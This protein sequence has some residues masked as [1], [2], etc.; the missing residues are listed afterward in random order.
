MN[1]GRIRIGVREVVVSAD[2]L[3]L[4]GTLA[5]PEGAVGVVVFAHGS[6]SSRF[7][8]RNRY[9]AEVLNDAALATLLFDLLTTDEE[10]D[11][12]N[13][14]DVSLL[15]GRLAAATNRLEVEPALCHLPIGY[16]GASTGAG[17]A[18]WAAA[19]NADAAAVVSRGGRPDLAGPRLAEVQA[20]TLLIV[21]GR[22]QVVLDLNRQALE[23]LTCEAELR[24]VQ[25]A[26]HLFEEPGAL[27]EVA[28]LARDWFVG[29][30]TVSPGR[31]VSRQ[32]GRITADRS[33]SRSPSSLTGPNAVHVTIDDPKALS[34][35]PASEARTVSGM[36]R[37]SRGRAAA[38]LGRV[39][40]SATR[41]SSRRW[42]ASFRASLQPPATNP[43]RE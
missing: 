31:Q 34:S 23:L 4:P 21:G 30:L 11:R 20:P 42:R 3:S 18:L 9:V 5:V 7:S 39:R 43:E 15:A 25:A 2:G 1:P 19:E 22:D 17:A 13:V 14:F 37:S 16:F 6:G 26:T 10:R 12:R 33:T 32:N 35:T 40:P 36:Q 28:A 24:I 38:L 41:P 29:H 27:E 8:P